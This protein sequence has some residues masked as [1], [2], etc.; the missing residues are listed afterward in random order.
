MKLLRRFTSLTLLAAATVTCSDSGNPS[1]AGTTAILIT[2][3]PFP[4]D[5]V[6]R[7]DLYI[8]R[9]TA[10]TDSGTTGG[11]CTGAAEV[12]AP[13]QTVDLLALQRGTTALLGTA[14]IP[15]GQYRS[16]CVTVNTDLSSL[17]LRDGRV[18]TGTSSP[19]IDWQSSGERIIKADVYDPISVADTGG[20]I[21]IHF[22]VGQSFIPLQDVTPPRSDSGFV[23]IATMSAFNP[24]TTG[25]ISGRI[26]AGT[27]GGAPITDASIRAFVGDSANPEGTWFVAATGTTDADGNFKL[28]YLLPS[29]RWTGAGWVYILAADPPTASGRGP[30]RVKGVV[31]TAGT[32]TAL[33]E[34]VAP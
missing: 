23:F 6:A 28:A 11:G 9:V 20:T 21:L 26:V 24:A 10:G 29:S 31:V 25:S 3:T 1:T 18:L 7:A 8:V 16:V 12:A 4:Y 15:A 27:P 2:D 17:T 30:A 32:E 19:V 5:W 13:N 22:D 14:T 33:G 34:L